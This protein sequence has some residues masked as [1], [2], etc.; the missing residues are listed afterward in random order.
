M[1]NCKKCNKKIEHPR[2]GMCLNCYRKT[3][4]LSRGIKKADRL[5]V[6]EKLNIKENKLNIKENKLKLN[7][8]EIKSNIKEIKSNIKKINTG[9][10][11]TKWWNEYLAADLLKRE[12]LIAALP[13]IK[14]LAR[15]GFPDLSKSKEY[16]KLSKEKIAEEQEKFNSYMLTTLILSYVED[17]IEI[18]DIS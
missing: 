10:L 15:K 14:E 12:D 11:S 16:K 17:L 3:T 18:K 6:E 13:L 8:K 2:R 5:F 4:G 7:I 1:I 9:N